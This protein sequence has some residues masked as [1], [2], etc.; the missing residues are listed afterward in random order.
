M[1]A[2][3]KLRDLLRHKG[4]GIWGF[5][6]FSGDR[7]RGSRKLQKWRHRK[8]AGVELRQQF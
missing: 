4:K 2:E 5:L 7:G 6:R 3:R 8:M 1:T